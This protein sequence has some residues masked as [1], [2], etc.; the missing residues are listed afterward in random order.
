MPNLNDE[1]EKLHHIYDQLDL[2]Y[3]QKSS[4]LSD[5]NK[6]SLLRFYFIALDNLLKIVGWVKNETRRKS[7]LNAAEI[8]SL[9]THISTLRQSYD[10]A[11]D[12][13]RDKLAAHQQHVDFVNTITWWN[14]IDSI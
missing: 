13:I 5:F 7:K 14:E 12:V 9:E 11:Y 3:E 8:A 10:A 6:R 2:L 1:L 4:S